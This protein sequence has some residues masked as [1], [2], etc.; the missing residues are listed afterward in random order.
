VLDVII[1][2]TEYKSCFE[3]T[4]APV[5]RKRISHAAIK[6][7][8]AMYDVQLSLSYKFPKVI[9][10]YIGKLSPVLV[11]PETGDVRFY[12]SNVSWQHSIIPAMMC[13]WV[14][15]QLK[16]SKSPK[17]IWQ[18]KYVV[19][20]AGRLSY[21]DR[22]VMS[23][24]SDN[25]VENILACQ[26][27]EKG[28]VF[29]TGYEVTHGVWSGH[30]MRLTPMTLPVPSYSSSAGGAAG[31]RN[32]Y[33]PTTTSNLPSVTK[34]LFISTD[35]AS[36]LMTWELYLIEHI[37]FAAVFQSKLSAEL[38]HLEQPVVYQGLMMKHIKTA[39]EKKAV[40]GALPSPISTKVD[41]GNMEDGHDAVEPIKPSS[42]MS[43]KGISAMLAMSRKQSMARRQAR[44]TMQITVPAAPTV[45]SD[46]HRFI[47]YF[48]SYGD[49]WKMSRVLL[50]QGTLVYEIDEDANGVQAPEGAE[51]ETPTKSRGS[52]KKLNLNAEMGSMLLM[53]WMVQGDEDK[54][55]RAEDTGEI[56]LA[57]LQTVHEDVT[58]DDQSIEGL[59]DLIM[60]SRRNKD[61][62][63]ANA[64]QHNAAT[65]GESYH[66]GGDE[67][68]GGSDKSGRSGGG[69]VMSSAARR[70]L[71]IAN[72]G[73]VGSAEDFDEEIVLLHIV[74]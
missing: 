35:T 33:R 36:E 30:C 20:H 39:K 62:E 74:R 10:S 52:R 49:L 72:G 28:A 11:E 44:G 67:K 55:V 61:D 8:N 32:A 71:D 6:H 13:G 1:S 38:A 21:F 47:G 43:I 51:Y 63:E 46:S 25:N 16:T 66:Q 19:L 59:F 70:M 64:H 53:G 5:N 68:E 31:G 9:R 2:T 18:R 23:L 50:T 42:I 58:L 15:L 65:D 14:N 48:K 7:L 22:D 34:D 54:V 56:P 17:P 24:L 12:N 27:C 41:G 69:K 60:H 40:L 4:E 26:R 73:S 29:L 37:K 45:L 57:R 3:G